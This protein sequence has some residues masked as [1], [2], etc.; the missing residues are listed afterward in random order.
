M[1]TQD[2]TGNS[3]VPQLRDIAKRAKP[4]VGEMF[5]RLLAHR[6]YTAFGWGFT[7]HRDICRRAFEEFDAGEI[8]ADE[9]RRYCTRGEV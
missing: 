8:G 6:T 1:R 9:L 3:Q 7:A 5:D 4:G 2:Q